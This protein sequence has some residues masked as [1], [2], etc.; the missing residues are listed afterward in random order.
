MRR[1]L[2]PLA[3]IAIIVIVLAA[4]LI[5]SYNSM[6]AKEEDVDQAYAQVENQ[7]QR[8]MDLIPNLVNTVKGFASHEKE[9]LKNVSDARAKL[10]GAGSPQ[11]QAE[12]NDELSGALS[13]LLVVVENYP[14]LKADANFRQLM[15]EL[16]GTENR[17]AVARQD[18]NAQVAAYNKKVKRFPGSLMAGIFGFDEKEY[19]KAEAGAKEAPKV[20]FE[21]VQE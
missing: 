10:A 2:G 12:A 16:A 19:F 1:S 3:I 17:L 7:L 8:R 5:T 20:D 18:Y 9:V 15:D 11:E 13:R 21:G 14:Q 6:V 4:M